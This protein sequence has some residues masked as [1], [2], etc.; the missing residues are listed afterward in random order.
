MLHAC[1]QRFDVMRNL[2]KFCELNK[3]YMLTPFLGISPL[4]LQISFCTNTIYPKKLLV[5]LK[6]K[7]VT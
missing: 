1:D 7:Q 5:C 4:C 3:A 6:K 2:K